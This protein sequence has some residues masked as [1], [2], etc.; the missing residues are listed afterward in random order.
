MSSSPTCTPSHSSS[1][2]AL[3]RNRLQDAGGAADLVVAHVFQPQLQACDIA[4]RERRLEI[5]GEPVGIERGRRDQIEA[6]RRPRLIARYAGRE[7]Q[8]LPW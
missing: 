2:A 8:S 4:A 7:G 5:L 1:A 6:G 3:L